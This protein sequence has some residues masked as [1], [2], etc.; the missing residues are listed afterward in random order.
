VTRDARRAAGVA[1]V[2][3]SEAGTVARGAQRER[4]R[5]LQP[6]AEL[7]RRLDSHEPRTALGRIGQP[8]EVGATIAARLADDDRW[9]TAPDRDG[10]GGFR[11]WRQH[12]LR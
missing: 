4:S 1:S 9:L 2:Q 3:A 5:R 8:D 6:E 12:Y 7:D 10:S 11:L